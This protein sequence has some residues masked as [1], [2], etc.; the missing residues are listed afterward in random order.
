MFVYWMMFAFPAAFALLAGPRRDTRNALNSVGLIL[1]LL[2]FAVLIGLR[3][4]V[5]AD[6][7]NY[8][9]I[10][11]YIAL[12]DLPTAM[13]T[14]D[15]GFNLVAWTS[16]RIG[17][18]VYGPNLVCG[19][20]LIIGLV[21]FCRRQD[22][23]WLA[24]AASVPYLVIVVGMGYVRQGAAIGLLLIALDRFERGRFAR[25]LAWVAAAAMF[26]ATAL[27]LAPFVALAIVRKRVVLIVPMGIVSIILFVVL[28]RS[29]VDKFMSDY[30]EAEFDSSG[31]V[32]RLLM[33]AVPAVLFIIF[34][35]RF[36]VSDWGRVLWLLISTCSLM[37]V[38]FVYLSPSTTLVDRIGLYFIPLQLFVFGNLAHAMQ[39]KGNERT[40][41]VVAVIAYYGAI[42]FVW[43][44]FATHSGAWVPY[45]FL[46]FDL[47]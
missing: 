41:L 43:L 29:R 13:G 27:C 46:P 15:P 24:I 6:W 3:F 34:R 25:S 1:L 14:G 10:I 16:T 17:A 4:E 31:A 12:E 38:V 36:P 45:K 33:N 44:N 32:V 37:L 11:G 20:L 40:A 8:E 21:I 39:L 26:H 5:G 2:G 7:S 18:E 47:L 28:L 30:V 19:T 9:E 35:K 22:N 42:L 23:V